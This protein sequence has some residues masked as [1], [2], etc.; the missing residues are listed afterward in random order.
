V[1]IRNKYGAKKVI[2][3]DINFDSKA[4]AA[5]YRY[6]KLL[7][8]IGEVKSFEMQVPFILQESF[9]HPTLKTKAGKP[10]KVSEIKYV[11]DFVVRFSDGTERVIDVKGVQTQVFKLKARIYIK[12]FG[13]LYIA[14]QKGRN[15]EVE[16]F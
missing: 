7:Q 14:T 8:K 1:A 13:P 5:F 16:E 4:E 10:R 6:L 3:D 15:W 11:T 12:K 2:V 9:G